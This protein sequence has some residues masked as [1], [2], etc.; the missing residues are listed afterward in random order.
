MWVPLLIGSIIL[1]ILFMLLIKSTRE[2]IKNIY[3]DNFMIFFDFFVYFIIIN[4]IVLIFMVVYYYYRKTI[5]GIKGPKGEIGITGDQGKNSYC[6]ICEKRDNKFTQIT[7]PKIPDNL[8]DASVIDKFVINNRIKE[9]VYKNSVKGL[10]NRWNAHTN[11]NKDFKNHG[12]ISMKCNGNVTINPPKITFNPIPK[13]ERVGRAHKEN[14]SNTGAIQSNTY[15]NGAI[16]RID[17]NNND[18]YSLQ[19]TQNKETKNGK[20]YTNSTE[21]L[22]GPSGR[23]GGQDFIIKYKD[24]KEEKEH[25]TQGKQRGKYHDFK[26]PEGSGIYRIDTLAEPPSNKSGNIKGIKFYCRDIKS[27][28][29]IKIDTPQERNMD[30]PYYGVNPDIKNK[31]YIYNRTI[32]R[33]IKKDDKLTPSF[34]SKVGAIH[35]Q[36]INALQFYNCSYRK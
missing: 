3:D 36:K 8:I 33:K 29:N 27:G 28:K 22:G 19:Y 31:R 2:Y 7:E 20:Q 32:C 14:C 25:I 11:L 21:N 15:I 26:C 16:L 4:L 30:G 17:E 18:L 23:W 1:L 5:S 12:D 24:K 9:I 10:N 34:I 6:G 35:G 13:V